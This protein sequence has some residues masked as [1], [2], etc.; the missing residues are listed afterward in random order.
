MNNLPIYI[1]GTGAI[2]KA[3]AVFL[4]LDNK[5]VILIRGSVD[6]Q[7]VRTE[8]LHVELRDKTILTASVEVNTLSNFN[9]LNGIVVLTNKS[10]GNYQLA[11]SLKNKTGQSPVVVLQNGLG[12]E[13]PFIDDVFPE[14]YRCVLFATSQKITERTIRFKPVAIS[15]IGTIKGSGAYLNRVVESLDNL[16]FHFKAVS[17]IQTIIWKKAIVN[18]VFN[19]VCPLLDIDNGI[20]H[21]NESALTIAKRV[22]REC[23]TIANASGISLSEEEVIESLVMI[24]K[25][26]DGQLIS[27]LQDIK[28]TRQTEIE[29]LNFSIVNIAKKLNKESVVT[30]TKLLGELTMLRSELNR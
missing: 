19:S 3:L 12:V 27:T 30:E 10:F 8:T 26:S 28:N 20:F 24:S 22:I 5:N 15:P 13:Q 14:I 23:V 17:D 1:I 11:Q 9:E 21:R 29:T 2:G 6:D 16:N 7:S 25:A 18:S 4:T